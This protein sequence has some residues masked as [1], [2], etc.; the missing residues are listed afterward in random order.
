MCSLLSGSRDP[1][2]TTEQR[3]PLRGKKGWVRGAVEQARE[4]RLDLGTDK[5][6]NDITVCIYGENIQRWSVWNGGLG[7]WRT[8]LRADEHFWGWIVMGWTGGE[9]PRSS[10]CFRSGSFQLSFI[11]RIIK[12]V[13]AVQSCSQAAERSECDWEPAT[14]I[15]SF[16]IFF[17][18]FSL[19]F[20]LSSTLISLLSPTSRRA[21]EQ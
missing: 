8:I 7:C 19:S 1:S 11:I 4:G 2:V 15:F 14:K 20:Y 17:F 10:V 5:N 21:K 3:R 18:T 6:D 16:Y 13:L 12:K 9:G